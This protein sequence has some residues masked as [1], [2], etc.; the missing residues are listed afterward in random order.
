MDFSLSAKLRSVLKHKLCRILRVFEAART[1]R[2]NVNNAQLN[3]NKEM[4][5]ARV[6]QLWADLSLQLR[7]RVD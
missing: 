5:V 4:F 3:E 6:K 2:T 7:H 1:V